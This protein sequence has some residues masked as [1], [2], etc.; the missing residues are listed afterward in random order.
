MYEGILFTNS[1]S[2]KETEA[3]GRHLKG[4]VGLAIACVMERLKSS[5]IV[6]KAA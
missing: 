3:V 2:L 4:K 5:V 6:R 1:I